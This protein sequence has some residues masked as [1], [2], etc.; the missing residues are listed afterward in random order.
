MTDAAPTREHITLP[1]S[2]DPATLAAL[3]ATP[4]G[5]RLS[6]RT[7][8]DTAGRSRVVLTVEHVDLEVVAETRQRLL[9]ACRERGVRAFV[10]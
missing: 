8:V 3:L 4:G 2:P 7:G 6:A 1:R 5:A 10:V 9:Q